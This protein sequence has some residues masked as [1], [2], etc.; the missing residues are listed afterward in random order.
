MTGRPA[1]P[2]PESGTSGTFSGSRSSDPVFG[3]PDE[4]PE[5]LGVRNLCGTRR[6]PRAAVGC[7][8]AAVLTVTGPATPYPAA[9]NSGGADWPTL[10]TGPAPL[11]PNWSAARPVPVTSVT[12]TRSEQRHS[13]WG[14]RTRPPADTGPVGATPPTESRSTGGVPVSDRQRVRR[15][16]LSWGTIPARPCAARWPA[17]AHSPIE[18]RPAAVTTVSAP[19]MA[20]TTARYTSRPA[21]TDTS[22]RRARRFRQTTLRFRTRRPSGTSSGT[23]KTGS[24]LRKPRKVPEVPL[25]AGRRAGRPPRELARCAPQLADAP[26]SATPQASPAM[27]R[28]AAFPALDLPRY[29]RP[30]TVKRPRRHS[31]QAVCAGAFALKGAP[32]IMPATATLTR[33]TAPAPGPLLYKVTDAMRVLSMSRTVLYEQIK[34]GRIRTVKQGRATFITAAALADYIALLE[35]EAG[36]A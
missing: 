2:P 10:L 18:C 28:E 27:S 35:R 8:L 14:A 9:L 25:P 22:A 7:H 11:T 30:E 24:E 21:G 26:A 1:L 17:A 5:G 16:A 3:V 29:Q 31:R 34:A 13:S 6:N 23:P 32:T 15:T 33:T 20:R 4:V 36:A 12:W 19:D